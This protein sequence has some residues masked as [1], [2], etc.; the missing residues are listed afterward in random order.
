[1]N[2]HTKIDIAFNP[3][4]QRMV[5]M[6]REGLMNFDVPYITEIV[7]GLW[8]GGC[9]T[10]LVLPTHINY[11]LSLYPWERY[12]INHE[13]RGE[14][15]HKMYDDSTIGVDPMVDEL[16]RLVNAWRKQGKGNVLVHCQAGLN[17]SSLILVRALILDGMKSQ[18]AIDLVRQKRSPACLCNKTFEKWLLAQSN[19]GDSNAK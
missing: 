2:D 17:R 10:G 11:I 3:M 4:E 9:T 5:G 12:T 16:A 18:E 13:M 15:Y 19:K 1:M 8:Q 6:T 7:E 14:M